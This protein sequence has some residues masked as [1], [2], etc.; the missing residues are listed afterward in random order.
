MTLNIAW[1]KLTETAK[2]PSKPKCDDDAG[3]D[4]FADEDVKIKPDMESR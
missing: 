2:K 1:K 4:L 3:Y